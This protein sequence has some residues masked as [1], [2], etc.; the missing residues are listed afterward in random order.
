MYDIMPKPHNSDAITINIPHN[1]NINP[2]CTLEG[3][4]PIANET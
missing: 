3:N 1:P 4:D 2:E